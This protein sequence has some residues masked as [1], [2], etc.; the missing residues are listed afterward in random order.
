MII[1]IQENLKNIIIIFDEIQ[2]KYKID[3]KIHKLLLLAEKYF[4]Y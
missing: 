4:L 3:S 2:I 1:K